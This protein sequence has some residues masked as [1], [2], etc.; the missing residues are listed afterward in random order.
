MCRNL[1]SKSLV[2]F[3]FHQKISF[4]TQMILSVFVS[5]VVESERDYHRQTHMSAL[6]QAFRPVTVLT[7]WTKTL[8]GLRV[9]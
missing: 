5:T 8:R 6:M 2:F 1:N 3:F 4:L 7:F 9:G